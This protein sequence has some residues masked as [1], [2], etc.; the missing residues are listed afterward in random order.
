MVRLRAMSGKRWE[1]PDVLFCSRWDSLSGCLCAVGGHGTTD[2]IATVT[3]VLACSRTHSLTCLQAT[4]LTQR[5]W[6]D[7]D[8]K[9]P[10]LEF[11]TQV[12]NDSVEG[13]F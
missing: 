13:F 7:D 5:V 4:I 12:W 3:H 1:H 8:M 2:V 11:R 6:K 10:F 9:K